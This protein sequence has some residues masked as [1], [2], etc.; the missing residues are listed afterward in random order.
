[1]KLPIHVLY[2]EESFYFIVSAT[3]TVNSEHPVYTSIDT[4]HHNNND[5]QQ[6]HT[7][8]R[9]MKSVGRTQYFVN[10]YTYTNNNNDR[11]RTEFYNLRSNGN[12]EQIL[13][14]SRRR[15]R[16][17]ARVSPVSGLRGN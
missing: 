17:K 12:L 1:M 14:K 16:C 15:S 6:C 9:T 4:R 11:V 13:I 5:S 8:S 3:I 2:R 7:N 10:P